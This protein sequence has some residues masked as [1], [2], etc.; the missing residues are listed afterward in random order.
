MGIG[1]ASSGHDRSLGAKSL[2]NGPIRNP[3]FRNKAPVAQW[4]SVSFGVV[5]ILPGPSR[6]TLAF[7][8]RFPDRMLALSL[9]G[10]QKVPNGQCSGFNDYTLSWTLFAQSE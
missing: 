7:S 8:L 10:S 2:R 4:H 6:L 9:D 5:L 3:A 1:R